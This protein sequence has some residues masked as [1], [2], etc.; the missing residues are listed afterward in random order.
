MM[1]MHEY[2]TGASCSS[3]A[4]RPNYDGYFS[5]HF[6]KAFGEYMLK[7]QTRA[8]GETRQSDNWKRG[9]PMDRHHRSLIR[10]AIEYKIYCDGPESCDEKKIDMLCAIVFRAQGLIHEIMEGK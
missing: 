4:G 7:H 3:E 5:G 8:D 1:E 10:H 2:Q 6:L 9:I